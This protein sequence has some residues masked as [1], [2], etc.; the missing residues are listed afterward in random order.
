MKLPRV[1]ADIDLS[2]IVNNLE[3]CRSLLPPR[4]RVLGVVKAD[5]YGHGAHRISSTL[6]DHGVAMLG[7]GDSNEAIQLRERGIET[8]ILVLGAVVDGEIDDLIQHHIIP[9]V[10]SPDRIDAFQKAAALQGIVLPV[11]LLIDTGMSLLGVTPARAID[12]LRA[13]HA[14]PNLDL[15]GIGT[16]LA[17][18]L[19]DRGFSEL[20]L[21]RFETVLADARAAGLPT[22]QIHSLASAAVERYTPSCGDMVRVGGFLYGIGKGGLWPGTQPALALRSQIVHFRDLP[23]GTP[24][25]YDGTFVTERATRVATIPVGYHDGYVTQLS[26]RAEVLVRGQRAPILGRV[27]MDYTIIDVSDIRDAAV[28]DQVTL[29]GDDGRDTITAHELAAWAGMPSYAIPSLLGNRVKRIYRPA[30]SVT[31]RR[32]P[33]RPETRPDP[34]P[35]LPGRESTDLSL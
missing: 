8:R 28:G 7:V 29:L 25:S 2:R 23:A 19:S 35:R 5:A 20:Q 24:I 34:R 6:A 15:Q 12:H 18:P 22:G 21:H 1:W 30:G 17:S 13:I 27:T 10:H 9:T 14:A 33:A 11:H 16:H 4:T 32:E 26:N 31:F 3:A